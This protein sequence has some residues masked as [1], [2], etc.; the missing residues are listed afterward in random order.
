MISLVSTATDKRVGC[1]PQGAGSDN[2]G[3]Q[4]MVVFQKLEQT[5]VPPNLVPPRGPSDHQP[6]TGKPFGEPAEEGRRKRNLCGCERARASETCA[7][8]TCELARLVPRAAS[9]HRSL[10]VSFR[11]AS[12]YSPFVVSSHQKPQI[13]RLIYLSGAE[14]RTA[15]GVA[16][17]ECLTCFC[18][19]L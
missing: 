7:S 3:W 17:V 11:H 12:A 15:V 16:R 18:H 6:A 8:D 4:D 5:S 10:D 1:R 2:F 13:Q 14:D 9:E 19:R